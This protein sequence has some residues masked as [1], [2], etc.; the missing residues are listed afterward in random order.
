M[1]ESVLTVSSAFPVSVSQRT[2]DWPDPDE[3]THQNLS[4]TESLIRPY[5]PDG[6]LLSDLDRDPS[7]KQEKP[8]LI[9]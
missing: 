9:I 2:S 3:G 5:S 1:I 8:D 6:L 7:A 4:S